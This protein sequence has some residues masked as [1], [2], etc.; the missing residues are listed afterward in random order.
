MVLAGHVAPLFLLVYGGEVG[1]ILAGMLMLTGFYIGEHIWVK[2]PQ[3][4]PL[5]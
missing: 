1:A 3:L 4:V 2:A 5:S